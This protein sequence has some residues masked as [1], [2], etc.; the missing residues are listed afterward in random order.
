MHIM[1]GCMGMSLMHYIY[2]FSQV[3]NKKALKVS[4]QWLIRQQCVKHAQFQKPI[5]IMKKGEFKTEE[6][7]AFV[8]PELHSSCGGTLPDDHEVSVQY[9]FERHG[10]CGRTSNN[11]NVQTRVIPQICSNQTGGVSTLEILH[12]T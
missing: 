12:I 7:S 9:P 11:A 5:R 8:V 6:L 3:C 4:G 10:L 1:N 2:L